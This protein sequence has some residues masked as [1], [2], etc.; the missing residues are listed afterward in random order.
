MVAFIQAYSPRQK[1]CSV[2]YGDQSESDVFSELTD[3]IFSLERT[4]QYP[5]LGCYDVS[6]TCENSFGTSS[7]TAVA[8]GCEPGLRYHY[9]A[10]GT[11]F[12]VPVAGADGCVLE[13]LVDGKAV[14]NGV[15]MNSTHV[16]ISHTLLAATGEH[17]VTTKTTGG[18]IC[19]RKIVTVETPCGGVLL[20]L[21]SYATQV[22][23]SVEFLVSVMEGDNLYVNL[24]Y[25]DGNFEVF[26][27][28]SAPVTLTRR[29]SYQSL[30]KFTPSLTVAN[31]LG[32]CQVARMV[33]VERPIQKAIM[34]V[35]N[36]KLLGQPTTFTFTVDPTLTPAMPVTVRLD[37]DDGTVETV[38]LG[39]MKPVVT[40]VKHTRIYPKLVL[41]V[42]SRF[43][44]VYVYFVCFCFILHSCCII[45]STVGWT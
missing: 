37:Y 8:A 26:Y 28:Q 22:N 39:A 16:T 38:T 7:E 32:V 35:T 23:H 19:S 4:H 40:P 1:T 29:H 41:L 33:S 42:A 10:K 45:V 18:L 15:L 34:S 31:A 5:G 30:G 43:I 2:D 44:C 13:V 12:V 11:N 3:P 9:I 25:G 14:S 6:L 24:S 21:G 20:S 17:I 27:V 36:V